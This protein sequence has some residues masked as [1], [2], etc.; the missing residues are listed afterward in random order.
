MEEDRSKDATAQAVFAEVKEA[1]KEQTVTFAA[2]SIFLQD[3]SLRLGNRIVSKRD[4]LKVQNTLRSH[5]SDEG[6]DFVRKSAKKAQEAFEEFDGSDVYHAM[7][8]PFP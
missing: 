6:I 8:D 1:L 3:T 2:L 5:S 4:K 7:I